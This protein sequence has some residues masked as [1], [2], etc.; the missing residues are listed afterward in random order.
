MKPPSYASALKLV[1]PLALGMA[2]NAA[3][4]TADRIFLAHESAASLEAVLP[5]A[6]LAAVFI[7]FFQSIVAYAGTFA[8]QFHGAKDE[9]G[10]RHAYWAGLVLAFASAAL[11]LLLLPLG[12]FVVSHCG[13]APH[14]AAREMEYYRILMFGALA[15]CGIMAAS[16]YLTGRGR[17]RLV[18]W[19]NVAGNMLNVALD[20]LLIFGYGAFPSLGMSGAAIATIVSQLVQML[21]LNYVVIREVVGRP[22]SNHQ[23]SDFPTFNFPTFNFQTFK[24]LMWDII[25]YG[26]PAGVYQVLN[27]LSFTIFVFASAAA[28]DAA[29][30]VS[31]AVFTINYLIFAPLEGF[32]IG[33][34]ILV[35][36]FQGA[37]D[38]ENA[39]KAGNRVLL[40]SIAY[41][42]AASALV[43]I[44][45]RPILG[46]FA[47]DS[48]T[49]DTAKFMSLGVTLLVLAITWQI[50][51]AIDTVLSG[52]L[53]GAGDTRFVM[54]WMLISAFVVWLPLVFAVRALHPTMPAFWMTMIAYVAV[55]CVGTA[56]RW[57]RG[58]WRSIRLVGG[59][60]GDRRRIAIATIVVAAM[61]CVWARNDQEWFNM[62]VDFE[63][64]KDVTFH[65]D[66]EI[67]YDDTRLA[68]EE[69]VAL[70]GY[71]FCPYFA[72][73][74]GHRTVREREASSRDF[75][76]E[77]RPTLDLYFSA[78]E[79]W[80]LKFDFRSRNE[81]RD[82]THIQP[83]V[84][85]RER[86]R[87]R[88]SWSV[89]DF[90]F[91]PYA[92]EEVFFTAKAGIKDSDLL[93]L[94][95]SQVGISFH[96]V[97]CHK[98]IG[99]NLYFMVQ[100]NIDDGAR[101]WRPLNIFG[102]EVGYHF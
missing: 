46:L 96:P 54:R 88:T 19:V 86:F 15:T 83:N 11:L 73:A 92:S 89:T 90:S 55:I 14:V 32:A 7:S 58:A 5:A 102:F 18:F 40:L 13:H 25:R 57:S 75:R 45:R 52:A 53:K 3:M 26:A 70:L 41:I 81:Y 61:S 2:N 27:L 59:G 24:P 6:M 37:K 98:N 12:G 72:F 9:A 64:Y 78:P 51:D 8:A 74:A 20:P 56:V 85:F 63:P 62:A 33:A 91:S 60:M 76:T 39:W 42:V 34:G 36:Q 94:I 47:A 17:T 80:T 38:S 71:R 21:I 87:L 49:I 10:C 93:D 99:C 77:H 100:H 84:R 29:L 97:P 67:E 101:E 68:N 30:A 23:L 31:N 35:G 22:N 66:Q 69:T 48:A 43:F 44:F 28:G 50:F 16:G 1:W 79:F 82:K 95:R 65:F 4:Q